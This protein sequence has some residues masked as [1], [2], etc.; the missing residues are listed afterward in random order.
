[1]ANVYLAVV[2]G[3]GSFSKL[4]VLKAL[5]SDVQ[6]APEFIQMFLDEARLSARFNHPNIVQAYEVGES[7]GTYFIAMEYLDGQTL[8][9]VQRKFAGAFPLEEELRVLADT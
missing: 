2:G 1:M 7:N 8:R 9:G 6:A 4:M 3:P 5:R